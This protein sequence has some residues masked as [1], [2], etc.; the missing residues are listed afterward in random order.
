MRCD[1]FEEL[2]KNERFIHYVGVA[3]PYTP[4]IR[5]CMLSVQYKYFNPQSQQSEL[6]FMHTVHWAKKVWIVMSILA[7]YRDAVEKIV[8][9]CGLKSMNGVP[10]SIVEDGWETLFYNSGRI[11]VLDN[12]PDHPIYRGDPLIEKILKEAEHKTIDK[13]IRS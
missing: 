1:G 11:F 4:G 10:M 12:M 3:K 9:G 6:F 5:E 13:I 7:E 2:L 8:T